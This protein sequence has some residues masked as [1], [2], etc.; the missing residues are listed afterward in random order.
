MIETIR[1]LEYTIQQI[2]EDKS[3]KR[4]PSPLCTSQFDIFPD[5]KMSL[6]KLKT[7]KLF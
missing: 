4:L 1:T 6:N 3:K 2:L 5:I 7:L